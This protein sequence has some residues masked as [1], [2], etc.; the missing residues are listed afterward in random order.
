MFPEKLDKN[1]LWYCGKCKSHVPATKKMEIYKL[2]KILMIHL[3][4]FKVT[5]YYR[6][7]I[8]SSVGFPLESLDVSSFVIGEKPEK[9]DL[10]A[11]S[12]HYGNLFGGHY[13]ATVKSFS[14]GKWYDCNDSS[15]SETKRISETSAY[16]LFYRSKSS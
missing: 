4:R 11:V 5:G 6:E 9:Y 16:V 13:T 15:V 1:N 10:F 8:V 2:P 3:K 12:N 14:S 7:K